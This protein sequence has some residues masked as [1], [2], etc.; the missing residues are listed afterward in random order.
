MKI[1]SRTQTTLP[2][3][4]LFSYSR[5]KDERGYFSE[6]Y[7][8]K[9]L[10][11]S[12]GTGVIPELV[13]S[14]ESFSKKNVVRG[15][16]FQWDPFM[17]KLIRTAYGHMIDLVVDIRPDS[18]TYGKGLLIDMPGSQESEIDQLLWIPPGFAHGNVFLDNTLI[19]YFCS[20]TYNPQ[21]EMGIYPYSPDIDWSLSEKGLYEKF[22]YIKDD[23][24]MSPKDTKGIFLHEWSL[25]PHA[26]QFQV[27][28]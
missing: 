4:V 18:K 26:K 14:N 17:G 1:L 13:Q 8:K 19:Q 12:D 27:N 2:G 22:L 15:L 24:I 11:L 7:N 20:G 21:G 10:E 23:A 3:I 25:S 5:F 28:K 9:E 6:I 16:H